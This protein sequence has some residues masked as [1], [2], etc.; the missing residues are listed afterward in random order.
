MAIENRRDWSTGLFDCCAGEGGCMKCGAWGSMP[1]RSGWRWAVE[2]AGL[3][4]PRRENAKRHPEAGSSSGRGPGPPREGRHA[5][6]AAQK[7][8]GAT[9]QLQPASSSLAV[10]CSLRA[11][12]P[13]ALVTA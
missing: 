12:G 9:A 13:A 7:P 2:A 8:P 5:R 11:G 4:V 6:V 1:C 3:C 10:T